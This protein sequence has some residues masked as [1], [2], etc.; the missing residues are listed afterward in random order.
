MSPAWKITKLKLIAQSI[1]VRRLNQYS[2]ETELK[3]FVILE[4][5][6]ML[7]KTAMLIIIS[8]CLYSGRQRVP[9]KQHATLF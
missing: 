6:L 5:T 7:I 8:V 3:V 2:I 9:Y 4:Q 1:G